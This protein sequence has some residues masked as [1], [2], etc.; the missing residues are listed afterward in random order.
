MLSWREMAKARA[1][2][3]VSEYR[4]F[5][6]AHAAVRQLLAHYTGRRPRELRFTAGNGGKPRLR[7]T[8]PVSFD[9]SYSGEIA[10]I[11]VSA[12]A[13][14][15]VDVER[16]RNIDWRSIAGSLLHAPRGVGLTTSGPTG[17]EPGVLHCPWRW[18]A[19]RL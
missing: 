9:R 13:E 5:V 7:A 4:R 15:G 2:R 16:V 3:H 11:A 6:A 18:K 17:P 8:P 12:G 1:F 10:L 19:G 14:I